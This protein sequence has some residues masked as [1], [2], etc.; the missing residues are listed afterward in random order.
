[1]TKSEIKLIGLQI[2][3]IGKFKKLAKS[4]DTIEKE[5]GIKS[6]KITLEDCFICPDIDFSFQG[7]TPMEEV[8]LEIINK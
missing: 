8:L 2:K 4:L 7:F 1:M 6:V 3:S 5:C